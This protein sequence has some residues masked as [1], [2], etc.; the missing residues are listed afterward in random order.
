MDQSLTANKN[1]AFYGRFIDDG[2]MIL[3]AD[4]AKHAL[5]YAKK[6]VQFGE[7]TLMWEV[8][9]YSL[10]FLDMTIYIDQVTGK[11][12]HRPFPKAHSHL[13]QIPFVSHHPLDVHK[14]TFPS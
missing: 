4:N 11:I 8:S 13:E 6:L 10:S 14:G 12:E 9:D 3:Y 7:L 1:I 5:S 2:S